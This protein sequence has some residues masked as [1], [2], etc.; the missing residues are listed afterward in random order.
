MKPVFNNIPVHKIDPS[1]FQKRKYFDADK[2]KDL[3]AS[4]KNDGLIEPIIV[5]PKNDRYE[6][7]AGERRLKA[8]INFTPFK[9]IQAKIIQVDDLQARR[10]SATENLQREDFSAIESIE[11]IVE[12][13]DAHLIEDNVYEAMGETPETRLNVLF[14]KLHSIQNSLDRQSKVSEKSQL[15]LHKFLQQL[16]K[17]FKKLPKRLEWKSFYVHDFPLVREIC[18]DIRKISLENQLNKSQIKAISE[19]K[20]T[21]KEAYQHIVNHTQSSDTLKIENNNQGEKSAR[22][23]KGRGTSMIL[24]FFLKFS[25]SCQ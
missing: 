20:K 7:I 25:A 2:L 24:C 1:P 10:I 6:L 3:A 5:R 13:I 12:I 14:G 23:K 17:I 21:S 18:E 16:E 11:A 15:L 19:V 9:T 4:I 8:T 22:K